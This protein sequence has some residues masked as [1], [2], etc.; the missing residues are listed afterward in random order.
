VARKLAEHL[1][2]Q[3]A[4]PARRHLDGAPRQRP[5]RVPEPAV[6][7]RG[8]VGRVGA[9]GRSGRRSPPAARD[10]SKADEVGAN[11]WRV[12]GEIFAEYEAGGHST[13]RVCQPGVTVS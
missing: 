9:A 1:S 6:R 10:V 7:R 11:A 8:R 2:A 13:A 4:H 3:Y 12:L 5:S